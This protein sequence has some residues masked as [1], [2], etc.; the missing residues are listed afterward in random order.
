MFT[1]EELELLVE[2]I[3]NYPIQGTMKSLPEIMRRLMELMN[4]IQAELEKQDDGQ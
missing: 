1:K 4:K 3:T 2:M